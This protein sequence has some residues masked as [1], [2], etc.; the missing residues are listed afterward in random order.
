[1]ITGT[2]NF[3]AQQGELFKSFLGSH[4][5]YHLLEHESFREIL[6]QRDELK[7]TFIKQEKALLDKKERLFKNR[8]FAKWGYNGSL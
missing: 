7:N 1:M 4:M 3:I 6:K 8:D 5:K 2:G